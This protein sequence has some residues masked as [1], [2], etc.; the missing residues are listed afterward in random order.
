MQ[1]YGFLQK[2][3]KPWKK[4]TVVKVG[5]QPRTY[6]ICSENVAIYSRNTFIICPDHTQEQDEM[7]RTVEDLYPL[8]NSLEEE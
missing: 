5:P 1:K 6:G 3:N 8:E 4:G 2:I 7:T